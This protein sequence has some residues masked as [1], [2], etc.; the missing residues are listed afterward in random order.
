MNDSRE[1][2]FFAR[3]ADLAGCRSVTHA[4][5][6]AQPIEEIK[7]WLLARFPRIGEIIES[8]A[9]AVDNELVALDQPLGRGTQIALLPPVSGG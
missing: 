9:W 4:F 2:L 6:N 3:V 7:A 1:I 5:G 8:C